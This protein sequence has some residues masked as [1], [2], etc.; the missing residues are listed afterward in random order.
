MKDG[1]QSMVYLQDNVIPAWNKTQDRC[2]SLKP[3]GKK[4]ETLLSQN[5]SRTYIYQQYKMLIA[6]KLTTKNI[7]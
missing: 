2:T 5:C 6:E 4:Q 7:K 3:K 1:C